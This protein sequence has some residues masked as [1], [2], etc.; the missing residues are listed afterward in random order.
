MHTIRDTP[1]IPIAVL[2]SALPEMY[3]QSFFTT[4]NKLAKFPQGSFHNFWKVISPLVYHRRLRRQIK[5]KE[6]ERKHFLLFTLPRKNCN[7]K[8]QQC[9][10][11]PSHMFDLGG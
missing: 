5:D 1:L 3:R 7:K 8:N 2:I 10:E 4:K 6:K 9:S 11:T